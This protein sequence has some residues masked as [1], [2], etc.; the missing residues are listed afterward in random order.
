MYWLEYIFVR[1]IAVYLVAEIISLSFEQL[2]HIMYVY[3]W[4][5]W[6]I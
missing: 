3:Q 4:D 5:R 6:A 1:W 2:G